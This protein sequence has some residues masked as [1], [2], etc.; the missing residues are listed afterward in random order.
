MAGK[1]KQDATPRRPYNPY[2]GKSTDE[3]QMPKKP[4]FTWLLVVPGLVLG[5][6]V[7]IGTQEPVLG[8]IF[9]AVMGIAVGSL[10]DKAIE[11]RRSSGTDGK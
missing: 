10:L 7:G 4:F 11:K 3:S 1:K 5:F 6:F 9:G 8:P 2:Y